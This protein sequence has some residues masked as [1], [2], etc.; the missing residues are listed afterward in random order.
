[1][2][3]IKKLIQNSY[4]FVADPKITPAANATHLLKNMPTWYY[5]T[6]PSNLSMHDLTDVTTVIPKH[7]T[8]IIGLGL[9]FCPTPRRPNKN[10]TASFSRFHKDLLTKVFFSGRPLV[11]E[12]EYNPKIHIGSDWE[13]KPWDIPSTIH[14]RYE[15]FEKS[16]LSKMRQPYRR[17][18]NLLPIQTRAIAALAKRTDVLIVSC[19][20]KWDQP[21]SK[22][23]P[24]LIDPSRTTS[25]T[26]MSTKSSLKMRLR[27]T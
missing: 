19:D 26:Q 8:T 21:Q 3:N 11:S 24:T 17:T 7:L 2:R 25:P 22:Q 13:P 9:K 20:K 10:P 6:R 12:E 23:P 15:D 27:I 18:T 1:M 4:G 14:K 5:F 16:I